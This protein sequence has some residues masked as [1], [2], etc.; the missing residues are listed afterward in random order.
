MSAAR[1]TLS[2]LAGLPPWAVVL[3]VAVSTAAFNAVKIAAL[4]DALS[5]AVVRVAVAWR[6]ARPSRQTASTEPTGRTATEL[7]STELSS[8]DLTLMVRDAL[9]GKT[10][11]SDQPEPVTTETGSPPTPPTEPPVPPDA[12]KLR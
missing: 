1:D 2:T 6:L 5:R 3:I 12:E 4:V 9:T 11:T 10:T 8:A 7:S